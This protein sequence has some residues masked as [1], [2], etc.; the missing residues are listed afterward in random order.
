VSTCA[1]DLKLVVGRAESWGGREWLCLWEK[2]FIY[3]TKNKRFEEKS[4][5]NEEKRKK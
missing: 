1:I 4:G 5:K 3:V 2:R